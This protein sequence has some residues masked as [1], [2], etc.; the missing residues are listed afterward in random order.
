MKFIQPNWPAPA[1]IKAYTTTRLGWAGLKPVPAQSSEANLQDLLGLPEEPFWL[2]QQHS[3]IVIEASLSNHQ[4]IGDASF[5]TEA[6]QVCAVLTADCLPLLVCDKKSTS[7]AAI[8]AGWRGLAAG[9]IEKTLTAL[10]TSPQNL[11]VWLG[12]AIG[13]LKFEVGIDVYRAFLQQ[14]THYSLAFKPYSAEKWLADIYT[15]ARIQ[16][17]EL[18]V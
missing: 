5:T 4:P 2:T 10:T 3:D 18:G 6:H 16:L 15:L 12:P 14:N 7:V 11:L 9:I 13:P 8:H 1:A 17:R